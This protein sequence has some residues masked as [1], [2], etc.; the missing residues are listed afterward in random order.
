MPKKTK[1]EKIIA[2]Y[3]RK[4]LLSPTVVQNSPHPP[5]PTPSDREE[6]GTFSYQ[7]SPLP[8]RGAPTQ[9]PKEDAILFAEIRRDLIKT[10]ILAAIAVSVELFLS[11]LLH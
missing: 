4:L 3:R 11:R 6:K 2:E 8:A 5:T 1:K 7:F 10:V 9:L